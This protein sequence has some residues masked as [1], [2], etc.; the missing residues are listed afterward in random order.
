M[1]LTSADFRPRT[2]EGFYKRGKDI[3]YIYQPQPYRTR[4]G[5]G[6]LG[7]GDWWV[8][9]VGTLTAVDKGGPHNSE[10]GASGGMGLHEFTSGG[11]RRISPGKLNANWRGFFKRQ[12]INPS[13][14]K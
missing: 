3:I 6:P 1:D 11:W 4:P 12:D 2:R 10:Q 13:K 8:D 7:P 9:Y 5:S 14:V